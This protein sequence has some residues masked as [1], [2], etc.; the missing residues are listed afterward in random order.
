MITFLLP[1]HLPAVYPPRGFWCVVL[2]RKRQVNL[3]LLMY[4]SGGYELGNVGEDFGLQPIGE[5]EENF[6]DDETFG[7]TGP[8][9]IQ[10]ILQPPTHCD[11]VYTMIG[12]KA[13]NY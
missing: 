13:M 5:E 2:V 1:L 4:S 10:T 6:D 7:D 12:N 11:Y 8:L 9:N 3:C